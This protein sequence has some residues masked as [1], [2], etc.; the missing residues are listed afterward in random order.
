MSKLLSANFTR[1]RKNRLFWSVLIFMF[2]AGI[3]IVNVVSVKIRKSGAVVSLDNIFF[4][5]V[6]P[7]G[8]IMAVFSGIF[9]GTEYSDGTIRNKLIIGHSRRSIYI[10]NLLTNMIVSILLCI[11]YMV[12]VVIIGIPLIG[13][14]T[15][16][17]KN[18]LQI[19]IGT[20]ILAM[21]F[22]SI[23]TMVSMICSNKTTG[24]VTSILFVV[25]LLFVAMYM[26]S[27]IQAPKYI[28]EYVMTDSLGNVQTQMA[29]NPDYITGTKRAV[30]EF[31]FDFIP[32]G[33]TIQFSAMTAV[34]LWE[35]SLY[36]LLIVVTTTFAGAMIFRKKDI[37]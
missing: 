21:A 14:F 26:N 2:V 3:I 15:L 6:L 32:T 35:M 34:H 27:R 28:E 18:I 31:L 23:F 4:Q 12:A 24:A 20:F 22:T 25:V 9:L 29:Q 16:D 8:I 19:C 30:Y 1:L 36:S 17:I 13:F 7:I 37:K 33:Q 11:S 10:S 5:Y